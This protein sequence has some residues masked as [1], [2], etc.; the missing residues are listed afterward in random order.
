MKRFI[1]I[2]FLLAVTSGFYKAHGLNLMEL[3]PFERAV[4][5]IKYYE[6]W[7]TKK[8][9]PYIGYGHLITPRDKGLNYG[10]SKKEAERLLRNDLKKLCRMFRFMGKDSLL[11]ASLAYNVGPYR[12]LGSKSIKKSQLLKRLQEGDRNIEKEYLEFSHVS[13]KFIPSILRRRKMELFLL[14]E[15]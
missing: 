11:L 3:P 6:G 12:I 7:H 1:T 9:Y 13:G 14:F 15:K 10:L 5:I 2:I 4:A 8:D